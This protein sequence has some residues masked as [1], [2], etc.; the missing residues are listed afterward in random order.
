[1]DLN[2][3][4]YEK[5][6]PGQFLGTLI[7]IVDL[8]DYPTSF[9]PKNKVRLVWV[10]GNLDGTPALDTEGNPFRVIEMLNASMNVKSV[11]YKRVSQIINAAPPLLSTSEQL[12]ELLLGRANMLYL[13][14]SPN[15]KVQGDF[16]INVAG[17]SPLMPGMN[18]PRTPANFVRQKDKEAA[19]ALDKQRIATQ[20]PPPYIPATAPLPPVYQQPP[21][22]NQVPP[23]QQTVPGTNDRRF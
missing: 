19:A 7:D 12:S 21:A 20:T 10:L 4:T 18:P 11:L 15:P 6:K 13:V 17:S 2:S 8:K 1:M 3:K 16:Y 22:T 5:P 23:P 9:G 14:Q